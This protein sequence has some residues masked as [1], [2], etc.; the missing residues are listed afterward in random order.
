MAKD[1]GD[2]FLFY[3][4]HLNARV[5]ERL[6]LE[7]K[8]R[9]A[10]ERGEFV[11]HYQP[12][13][14]LAD[15]RITGAEALLRWRD[16]G[17]GSVPPAQFVPVLEETGLIGQV[18][19]WVMREAV[20]THRALA[21]GGRAAP[22]IA[23]NVSAI[24]L[25][26]QSF[27]DDVRGV[28]AGGGEAAGL[29]LEI[30]ESLLMEDIGDSLRK[31]R[32]VRDMGVRIALDDFGTGYSSLAYLSR[33]PIDTVKID[34]GFVR[35]MVEKA[36]DESVVS[37]IL[38]LA[39]ALKLRTVAEGVESQEQAALLRRLRCDEMQGYLFSPAVPIDKL[40]RLL[41]AGG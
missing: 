21:S 32:A 2:R 14:G 37:A 9:R 20:K 1:T 13:V 18:G 25:R 39:H 31:L 22:R 41:H 5:A 4:P 29:D 3:T 7:A 28:L 35:S 15:G 36:E 34:R 17:Q 11:L 16:G 19:L 30:T 6:D 23:V 40:E 12:K 8:L 38:S 24:Q 10:V 33:L 26:G 27:V